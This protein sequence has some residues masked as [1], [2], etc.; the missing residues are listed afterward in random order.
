[1]G[2]VALLVDNS[3][4]PPIYVVTTMVIDADGQHRGKRSQGWYRSWKKAE[5]AL[6]RNYADLWEC[7]FTHAVIEEVEEG[8]I[9]ICTVRRWYRSFRDDYGKVHL[10]ERLEEDPKPG[11]I[12]FSIG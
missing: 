7:D 4:I 6:H 11:L 2:G 10:V 5:T 9:P 8:V 1:M 3:E 12:N